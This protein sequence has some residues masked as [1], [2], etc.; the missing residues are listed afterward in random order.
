MNFL[1]KKLE[2]T[3][4]MY[5]FIEKNFVR[6]KILLL[7]IYLYFFLSKFNPKFSAVLLYINGF[8]FLIE[9]K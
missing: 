3:D 2:L 4:S 5:K 8:Q 7:E 6:K 1:V 9:K